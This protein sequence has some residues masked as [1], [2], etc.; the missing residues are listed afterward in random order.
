M[1]R[2]L[3]LALLICHGFIHLIGFVAGFGLSQFS[4]F[5]GKT[6]FPVAK[7]AEVVFTL[8][9]LVAMLLFLSSGVMYQLHKQA[10]CFPALAGIV[11][12]QFLVIIYWHDAKAGTVANVMLILP[13]LVGYANYTFYTKANREAD[14]IIRRAERGREIVTAE[15]L[16][17]LPGCVRNWLTKSNVVGKPFVHTV[18][19]KQNGYMSIKPGGKY[20]SATAEQYFAI[21][22]PAFVWT[23]KVAMM[24]GVEITGRDKYEY[25]HGNMLI[26]LYSM[27]TFANGTGKEIDQ[28]TMLRY[29]GEICWFPSAALQPYIH[30]QEVDEHRAKATMTYEGVTA[31]AVFTF[32]N[33]GRLITT[34]AERYMGTGKD[35]TLNHWQIPCTAWRTFHGIQVPVKGNAIW[36]LPA[37]D[38]DYYRWEITDIQ[39]NITDVMPPYL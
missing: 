37:G 23:V 4:N 6:L 11:L 39:Y 1:L 19:L 34:E 8:L 28:G 31:S 35:A 12:S 16:N 9:W 17:G 36:K 15:M 32:D 30:W 7:Q 14:A 26:K 33:D 3:L 10:W 38:Y 13:A 20:M 25:G 27:F 29:L 5:T 22:K 2:Y 24:P 21:D 18:Y